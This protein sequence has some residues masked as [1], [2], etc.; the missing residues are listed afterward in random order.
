MEWNESFLAIEKVIGNRRTTKPDKMNG[1]KIPDELMRRVLALADWAPN[2][3]E[4]EPWRFVV[5]SG[6][7][8]LQFC[9][10]HAALYQLHT[11]EEKFENFKYQKLFNMGNKA[12]H[13]MVAI[14]RRGDLPKIPAWEERAATACAI[15]NVLL[16]AASN[17]IASYWGSGGMTTH[18][19]M[20]DYLGL[21]DEDE[22]L[23]ILYFGYSDAKMPAIRNIPLE[24][25]IQWHQ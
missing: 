25:K 6:S 3:G 23:G 10:D 15:Q 1:D 12:S 21:R 8:V 9:A 5:Y 13:V 4:T 11:P 18:P 22:V 14:M 24:E 7:A 20:K 19:A 16:G 17:G 2:H